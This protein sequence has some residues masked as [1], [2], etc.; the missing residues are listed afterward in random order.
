MAD[1]LRPAV[2]RIAAGEFVM[3]AEDGDEDERPP[4]A[5]YLDEFCIGIHPVTNAEYARFVRDTS[6]PSPAIGE[7]PLIASGKLEGDFRT[8]AAA[9]C[10]N[11]GTFPAGRDLNPVTLV[12][13][14]DAAAYCEWLASQTSQPIRLPTEAE[15]ERAARGGI[16]GQRFP[17]GDAMNPACAH[18][19][20]QAGAKAESGTA[21]VGSYPA[22]GFQLLDMAGNVWEWVSDWYAPQYYSRAQLLNPRGPE[23]GVMRIVRG[24]SWVNADEGYLRC[25]YRHKVPPDSYAYSIGFRVAYS[26]T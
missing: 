7:I 2:V 12:R 1:E 23:S 5:A 8:L 26:P 19:L 13:Y 6:H 11:N 20:P 21:A 3:G 15:W 4:H 9:Y 16:D 17:W 14:E 10:W 22:T 24:G 25:A 18:V